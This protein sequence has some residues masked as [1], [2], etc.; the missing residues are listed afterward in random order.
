MKIFCDLLFIWSVFFFYY[1]YGERV[2][3]IF[4]YW[5]VFLCVLMIQFLDDGFIG[6]FYSLEESEFLIFC[7]LVCLMV[8]V[9][10]LVFSKV[11]E[12]GGIIFCFFG[13]GG[14][15]RFQEGSLEYQM[16]EFRVDKLNWDR[17]ES[18]FKDDFFF[19]VGQR[20]S[21]FL[22]CGRRMQGQFEGYGRFFVGFLIGERLLRGVGQLI[23]VFGGFYCCRFRFLGGWRIFVIGV[24]E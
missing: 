14:R 4:Q 21:I 19:G 5:L 10:F 9:L 20:L 7:I 6:Q 3:L 18:F 13:D 1:F 2:I 16:L 15:I 8:R 23:W 24:V 22:V 11:Q 12:R 17:W